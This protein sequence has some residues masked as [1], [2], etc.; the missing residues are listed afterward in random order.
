MRLWFSAHCLSIFPSMLCSVDDLIYV[1]QKKITLNHFI[2]HFIHI[3][4]LLQVWKN[5]KKKLKSFK[6]KLLFRETMTA[7]VNCHDQVI[8]VRFVK[9]VLTTFLSTLSHRM[10]NNYPS[11]RMKFYSLQETTHHHTPPVSRLQ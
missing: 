11:W 9:I 3:P 5:R 1:K 10:T 2:S 4:L 7:F 6:S 8:F